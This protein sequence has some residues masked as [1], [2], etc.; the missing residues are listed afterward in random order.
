MVSTPA[1]D[2]VGHAT[3]EYPPGVAYPARTQV[4]APIPAAE[5]PAGHV[6]ELSITVIVPVGT[7]AAVPTFM[8]KLYWKGCSDPS[9]GTVPLPVPA[10]TNGRLLSVGSGN[11]GRAIPV[12]ADF[13]TLTDNVP[14]ER[15]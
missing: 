14:V 10:G 9:Y 8:M 13:A 3:P 11:L 5:V 12:I 6:V 7:P 2:D 4:A 1:P 15:P